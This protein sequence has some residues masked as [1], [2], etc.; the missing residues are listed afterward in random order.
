MRYFQAWIEGGEQFSNV[1]FS[2]CL[3][4]FFAQLILAAI[5]LSLSFRFK[6]KLV[7]KKKTGWILLDRRLVI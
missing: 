6:M 7:T 3:N 4:F 1:S 5:T 2:S